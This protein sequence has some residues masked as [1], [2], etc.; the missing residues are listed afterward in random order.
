MVVN[1][2]TGLPGKN[3]GANNTFML[4]KDVP[5]FSIENKQE[6]MHLGQLIILSRISYLIKFPDAGNE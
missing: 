2:N 6:Q 3:I 1:S 4:V 5:C